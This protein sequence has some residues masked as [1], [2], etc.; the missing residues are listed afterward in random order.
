MI[1]E[2]K[3]YQYY[4]KQFVCNDENNPALWTDEVFSE[5]VD[6]NSVIGYLFRNKGNIA[7]GKNVI[8][9]NL[10][11]INPQYYKGEIVDLTELQVAWEA[12]SDR[13]KMFKNPPIE[14]W[15]DT[16]R[17]WCNKLAMNLVKKYGLEFDEAMSEIYL[18]L[19]K[20]YDKST[21]YVGNLAYIENAVNNNIRSNYRKDKKKLFLDNPRVIS[22]EIAISREDEDDRPITLFDILSI[23]DEYYASKDFE[24]LEETIDKM[25]LEEFSQRE[26]EQIKTLPASFIPRAIYR[27]LIRWRQKHSIEEVMKIYE[28]R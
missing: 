11:I 5:L 7:F 24:E 15:L 25:L 12:M 28:G 16:K 27:R 14:Q 23:E 21:V 20:A 3:P 22:G 26:I 19:L 13:D 8:T 18:A 9:L 1:S 6:K 4:I 2:R 10:Y 17:E